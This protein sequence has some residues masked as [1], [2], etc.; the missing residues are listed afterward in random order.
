MNSFLN[1]LQNL[2]ITFKSLPL[3]SAVID[4][5]PFMS[6]NCNQVITRPWH[7]FVRYVFSMCF[8]K[9]LQSIDSLP[10]TDY[11]KKKHRTNVGKFG[12]RL[13]K[14]LPDQLAWGLF[15]KASARR[16]SLNLQHKFWRA[17]A[18][19]VELTSFPFIIFTFK[20]KIYF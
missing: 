18:R 13:L 7:Q 1:Y 14:N 3:S 5:R 15:N 16:N 8:S 11:K 10:L 9:R 20:V 4:T 17:I 19:F 2:N 12:V 6:K